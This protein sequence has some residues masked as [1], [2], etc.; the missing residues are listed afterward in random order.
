MMIT[1]KYI[2]ASMARVSGNDENSSRY[3]GDSLQLTNWI[4]ESGATFHLTPQVSDI[5][6][7][8]LEDA[9]KYIEFADGHYVMAKQKGK[10]QIIMWDNNGNPLITALHN[11]LLAPDLCHMLFSF[12]VLM[13]LGHTYLFQKGFPRCTLEIGWKS[14]TLPRSA[15]R[16]CDFLVKTKEKA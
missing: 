12:I 7:G 9:D 4:F 11:A 15:Q 13:N 1:I 2:Y 6:P 8:L 16:K 3:F 14:V 10:V 5:I